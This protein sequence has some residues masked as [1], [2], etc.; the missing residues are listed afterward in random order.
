M[1]CHVCVYEVQDNVIMIV[2]ITVIAKRDDLVLNSL[3]PADIEL[4]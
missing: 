2:A 1:S 4:D 3:R